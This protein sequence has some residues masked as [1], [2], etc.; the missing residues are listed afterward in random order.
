MKLTK[1]K[2][3]IGEIQVY[4]EGLLKTQD[5]QSVV[6]AGIRMASLRLEMSISYEEALN[7]LPNL[8][9]D[10]ESTRE[11]TAAKMKS[12]GATDAASTRE[13]KIESFEQ[14]WKYE[15]KDS[16]VK[17]WKM[18]IESL[19]VAINCVSRVQRMLEG[20][21]IQSNKQI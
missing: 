20:E 13:G 14:K 12:S 7:G 17:A 11:L 15:V 1:A 18:Y 4:V 3:K 5:L 9:R 2:E 16:E 21:R 19:D 6:N 10:Y 8:K